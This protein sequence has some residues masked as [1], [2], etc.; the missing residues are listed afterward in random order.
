LLGCA[1]TLAL[2]LTSPGSWSGLLGAFGVAF[3]AF[4]TGNVLYDSLLPAVASLDE[5][6]EVS[7]RGFA[8]GYVGGGILLAVHLAIISMPQRFGLANAGIATR[9]A[10][11]SVAV[12]WFV[13]S[14]PMFRSVP[15]PE[16]ERSGVPL[17]QLPGAVLRQLAHTLAGLRSQPD[18]LR[19]LV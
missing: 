3:I 8:W 19:F 17:R 12:W 1:G 11:A 5:M 7:A 9:V 10:F 2:A 4:A 18:L 16:A 15:E 14:L 13:F 6:H